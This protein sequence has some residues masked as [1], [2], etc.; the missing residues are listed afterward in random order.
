MKTKIFISLFIF[1]FLGACSSPTWPDLS[2]I[3]P[4]YPKNNDTYTDV[5]F[6]IKGTITNSTNNSA[7]VGARITLCFLFGTITS[8]QTNSERHY[9]IDYTY[10]WDT[11]YYPVNE[12]YLLLTIDATGYKQKV[13]NSDRPEDIN[14][15]RITEDWQIIDVQ[16]EPEPKS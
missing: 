16:L 3:K 14:H 9:T 12:R 7:V 2:S 1:C 11:S 10:A 13:I 8:A 15:V 5:T 6:R 4:N